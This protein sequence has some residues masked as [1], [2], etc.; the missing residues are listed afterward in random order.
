MTITNG[1]GGISTNSDLTLAEVA[2]VNN[3]HGPAAGLTAYSCNLNISAS[4]ISGNANGGGII[5][6]SQSDGGYVARLI[7][8]TVSG[9]SN[10]NSFG[11]VGLFS[12]AGN[13]RLEVINSTIAGN[14]APNGAG[15][16]LSQA[17]FAGNSTT[18]IL[19]NSIFAN[20]T[21]P[22]FRQQSPQ[23]GGPVTY[24]SRGFNLA[25]DDSGA[26]LNLLTDQNNANAGLLPLADNGGPTS[27]HA[28]TS[29][30]DALDGG[31]NSGSGVTASQ[32]GRGYARTI[33]LPLSNV[34]G[35]DGTDVGAFEAQ[36]EPEGIFA[37][38]FE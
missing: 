9:N 20:N 32:R 8:S 18:T 15:A 17:A 23:G 12:G 5:I 33:D 6:H 11:A 16:I 30:S 10:N 28:L 3:I 14:N 36:S 4:T 2:L 27:T 22:S 34:L 25:T 19:R 35:G 29:F 38:G 13:Q 7:N 24:I 37:D 31:N 1:A 26:F 21:A